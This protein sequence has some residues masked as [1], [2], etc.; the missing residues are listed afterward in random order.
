MPLDRSSGH[1]PL[2]DR[3]EAR[4]V[5]FLA[6][7]R[8][9]LPNP[10]AGEVARAL[11]T[12]QDAGISGCGEP[13]LPCPQAHHELAKKQR[14]E[15]SNTVWAALQGAQGRL[16]ER[17]WLEGRQLL[18][19]L[20][21]KVRALADEELREAM[22]ACAADL[23]ACIAE[24]NEGLAESV[25]RVLDEP[26]NAPPG[27]A[28]SPGAQFDRA[29]TSN[30]H[31]L[32]GSPDVCLRLRAF[33]AL[34]QR[35][36]LTAAVLLG[37]L[38]FR[39]TLSNSSGCFV[40]P[41]VLATDSMFRFAWDRL[42]AQERHRVALEARRRPAAFAPL[43]G[44]LRSVRGPLFAAAQRLSRTVPHQRSN[45][46]RCPTWDREIPGRLVRHG[47]GYWPGSDAG[48]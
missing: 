17:A 36:G 3:L 8:Y 4:F 33:N 5:A 24:H 20:G 38:D 19:S 41:A 27:A 22:D 47:H 44:F 23:L 45:G 13:R 35:R 2:V 37:Q 34:A 15:A 1:A 14:E 32:L 26:A 39:D 30:L 25:L 21:P 11:R 7:T 42:P 16:S 10:R 9:V 40:R 43:S 48:E 6:E 12:S 31:A 28:E 18:A 46:L 29:D